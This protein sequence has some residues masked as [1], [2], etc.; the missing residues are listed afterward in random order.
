MY[1]TVCLTITHTGR[2]S[3]RP[4]KHLLCTLW[5][6]CFASW[7]R[8]PS[9]QCYTFLHNTITYLFKRPPEGQNTF[10]FSIFTIVFGDWWQWST[11]SWSG[12]WDASS[13][14]NVD[15]IQWK[16]SIYS[17]SNKGKISTIKIPSHTCRYLLMFLNTQQI[18]QAKF[19][20]QRERKFG[21]FSTHNLCHIRP[22]VY[23]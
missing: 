10:T 5:W 20:F 16:N 1:S 3:F 19:S 9:R 2:Q 12:K 21:K 13:T 8:Q 4:E 6:V 14:L 7:C 22:G 18:L 11:L 15:R 17:T 23:G